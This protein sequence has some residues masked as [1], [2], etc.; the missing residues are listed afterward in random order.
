MP[1]VRPP[2]DL[3]NASMMATVVRMAGASCMVD[4]CDGE[5]V[6]LTGA[7]L[8]KGGYGFIPCCGPCLRTN[9]DAFMVDP[10]PTKK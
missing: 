3:L 6:V 9:L 1:D 2:A 10:S 7:P 8:P 5:V 4:D